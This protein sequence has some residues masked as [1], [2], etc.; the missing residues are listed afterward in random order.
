MIF[1]TNKTKSS[2]LCL[3]GFF[4]LSFSLRA[5]FVNWNKPFQFGESITY[6]IRYN[7]GFVWLDAG[8]VNFSVNRG[9]HMGEPVFQFDGNGKTYKKYD[10]IYKVRDTYQAKADTSRLI[11]KRFKRNVHEGRS[12]Y[13]DQAL[14]DQ[15]KGAA[16]N[17][18]KKAN[19]DIQRDT[20]PLVDSLYD[21][22]SMIYFSRCIDWDEYK[23]GDKIPIRLYLDAEVYFTHITYM[24]KA[25]KEVEGLGEVRCILFK[26][27]LIEGTI[28]P[29]GDNMTV[30]VTDDR[31]KIPV[32][33]ETPI[34]VG[35]IKVSLL[36]AKG[37]KYPK[38][39]ERIVKKEE[40]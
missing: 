35:N 16:Y 32:Y 2:L 14:F 4:L 8:T 31:N 24:G 15:K 27:Q 3:G 30:W 19:K 33:I 25:S 1:K 9:E 5:Q 11:P 37:L 29:G 28:F 17:F 6:E 20:V 18:F 34:L 22:L 21:V 23:L 36:E 40:N 26:P 13:S 10:W 38:D 39:F 12:I 7:W